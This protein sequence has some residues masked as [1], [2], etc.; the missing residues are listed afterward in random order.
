MSAERAWDE[1]LSRIAVEGGSEDE[2]ETFYSALYHCF[3]APNLAND[4]DGQ[5]RGTDLMVHQLSA[6]EGDHYTVFSLWD[7][8]RALH[9]LLN[10]IEPE[11][12]RDFVRTMLRM[13]EQGGQLPV[14]E[15]AGNYTGCMIGYHSVPVIA[16]AD[17]WGI[18]SFD[19]NLAVDAMVQAA[20][21][22]H[23]G[24][25]PYV[26]LGYIP[27]NEEHESVSKTLEYA[28][29]DACISAFAAKHSTDAELVDRFRMRALNYR[30][31]FNKESGFFQPKRSAA[32]LEAFD[33][34]EVN[35][36]YTE[37]NGWQYNFFVPHDVNGHV[38]LLG[39]ATAYAAKL[40]AMFA[41]S[42]ETTGRN[43]A[44][45]TGL[46]GQYAHGNEPSHHMAYLYPFVGKHHRTA[47]LVDSIRHTL[48]SPLPD[49][50]S[51]N[52]DC[53]QMSA[54]YVWS[55]L[56]MYPV[57]PGSNQLILGTPMFDEVRVTPRA[58]ADAGQAVRI[59]KQGE[60]KYV[61]S[62]SFQSSLLPAFIRKEQLLQGGTLNYA[63]QDEPTAFGEDENRWPMEQWN[64][65]G[66]IPVPVIHAPRTF[67]N[68]CSVSISTESLDA[69]TIEY[70][71]VPMESGSP[72]AFKLG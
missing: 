39:G 57:T 8:F 64:A 70:A 41:S 24:L 58:G 20:D 63:C 42:S 61:R 47:E 38:E 60:G 56:G 32:W 21:S 72:G 35:F 27:L 18:G 52:E 44:D 48:Y 69:F 12:S 19:V 31:L 7:T 37:A 9:P 30:N 25:E 10:W 53:G 59:V 13:Y 23:L 29:D 66:F 4:V 2:V 1:Q 16:D 68:T 14:W 26:A 34:R 46:I 55:A 5:Y 54:W 6:D 49:G 51:G 17:A 22:A 11:R 3:T 36:N 15:L 45:I 65:D 62:A 50:L 67:K 33:P 28:F 71:L 40:D 43:Q